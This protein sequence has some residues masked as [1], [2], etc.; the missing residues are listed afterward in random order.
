VEFC[1]DVSWDSGD[2]CR[3]CNEF[4]LRGEVLEPAADCLGDA[5]MSKPV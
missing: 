4:E 5:P 1:F 3:I 2:E